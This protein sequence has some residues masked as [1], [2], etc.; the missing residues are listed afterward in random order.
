MFIRVLEPGLYTEQDFQVK[1][2]GDAGV[3]L[4]VRDSVIIP[5]GHTMKVG[6]GVAIQIPLGTVGWITSRSSAAL[7][8]LL[9]HEGK[10]DSG[11]RGE[12]HAII[13]NQWGPG[14]IEDRAVVQRGERICQLLVLPIAN[15]SRWQVVDKLDEVTSRG[16]DGFGSTGRE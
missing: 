13:T 1:H 7:S 5:A 16:A 9:V 11:Y 14:A 6:L 3:D 2:P 4:R 15:P 8:G 12:I 10:I